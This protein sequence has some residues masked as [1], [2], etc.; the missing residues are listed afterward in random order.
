MSFKANPSSNLRRPELEEIWRQRLENALA[1]YRAAAD[2]YGKSLQE[3]PRA[4]TPDDLNVVLK[5]EADALSRVLR[6]FT[7]LV[8]DGKLPEQGDEASGGATPTNEI[9]V[10][11]ESIR[12]SA[13]TLRDLWLPGSDIHRG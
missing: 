7:D 2:A 9:S 1:R 8:I 10:G 13:E 4:G 3:E 12:D 6:I 5:A 11:D